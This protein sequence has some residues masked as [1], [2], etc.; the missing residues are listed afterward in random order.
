MAALWPLS[1]V[2]AFEAGALLYFYDAETSTPQ[3]VYEDA[4]LSLVL[5][6]PI[7]ANASGAFPAIYLNPDPGTYRQR[8]T[9]ADGSTVYLD[10]DD[11]DVPQ[12]ANF[13][14]PDAGSTDPTLLFSTGDIKA[15]HGTGA[16][17][18]WVRAAGRSIGSA[19]SSATERANADCEDLFVYLWTQDSTL[20][21]S[22][23]RGG[24]AASDWAA[25]KRITLPDYRERALVGLAD[26]GNS[27]SSLL[28]GNTVDSGETTITL[29]A[30]LG[31]GTHTLTTAQ[32][33][34]HLH[35]AGTLLMPN[36]T[37]DI[38]NTRDDVDSATGTHIANTA[39]NTSQQT[40]ATDGSGTASIT[41]STANTGSGS[42]HPNAQPSV[43]VTWYLKL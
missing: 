25:N 21:V 41:G 10:D 34:S 14:P 9:T 7:E 13:S 24:S 4:A 12:A 39:N 5:D 40:I 11:V 6:Q 28:S 2:P 42:A 23:G 26:M 32:L 1:R 43:L 20:S 15:K 30:T 36:H 17:S 16:E 37:H 38:S 22:G 27:A 29:G 33:P 31:T 8:A 18:G 35:A 3:P 19:T